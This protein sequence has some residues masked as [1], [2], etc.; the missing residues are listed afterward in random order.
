[1]PKIL[2]SNAS[3][4]SAKVRMAAHQAGIAFEPVTT[5]TVNPPASLIEAN[6]LGKI[7]VFIPDDGGA[8]YDSRVIIQYLNR[9]SKGSLFPRNGAKRLEA[10]QMEALCDGIC[11]AALAHVYERRMRPEE[12]VSQTWLERQWD[13]VERALDL[14]NDQKISLPT[15][16]HAGH[17][18]LRATLAYL[19]L[20]FEGK[21]E[22]KRGKLTRWA[23]RFDR[24]FPELAKY[25]PKG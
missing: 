10:E 25:L 8:I 2:F 1:M 11:D 15:K 3:P 4:Y 19:A 14:V 17:L 13:K 24:K 18:A 6:P 20:R 7:P 22:K 12:H 9:E 23:D 21:W 5:E 16:V